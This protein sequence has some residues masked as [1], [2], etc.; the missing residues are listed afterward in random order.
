MQKSKGGRPPKYRNK[1]EI[2]ELI[3]KYFKE[4]EGGLFVDDDDKPVVTEKGGII[5]IV[6]PKPPTVT[7]IHMRY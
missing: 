7:I 4:C 1:E 5:Y 3:E 2:E 6:P